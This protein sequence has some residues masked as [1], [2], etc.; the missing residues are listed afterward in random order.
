MRS[1]GRGRC[2][3]SSC[4]AAALLSG[5]GGSQPPIGAPGTMPQGRAIRAQ[6]RTHQA[7]IYVIYPVGGDVAIYT[8]SGKLYTQEFIGPLNQPQAACADKVG[9]VF[10]TVAGSSQI[11]EYNHGG[12]TP[13]ATLN[14]PG[15]D[16]ASC[17][18]DPKSGRIA[19]ANY[20][21][22]GG[23]RGSV[24][25]YENAGK[26]PKLYTDNQIFAYSFCA[27]DSHG[28][29]F[30]D[31]FKRLKKGFE[32]AELP[33][34]SKVFKSLNLGL[35][36]RDWAGPLQWDSQDIALA[37]PRAHAIDR[38]D[39]GRIVGSVP[40]KGYTG[41][42]FFV[43]NGQIGTV[44]PVTRGPVNFWKYPEGG[45]RTRSFLLNPVPMDIPFYIT[46]SK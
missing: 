43:E 15:E 1:L 6:A 24:S 27:Y 8:M 39:N 28:N 22:S 45:S 3:L 9:H 11:V 30:V 38:L 12:T 31:G 46:V 26:S 35:H 14:D 2:A 17:S 10:I 7:L 32:L 18:I 16:P 20:L 21:A 44:L 4:V 13:V 33:Y 36:M 40:L 29:L 19:V 25:I 34:G 5:C 23:A 42:D 37:D 41:S